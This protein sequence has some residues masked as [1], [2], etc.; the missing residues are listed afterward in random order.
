MAITR[1]TP[2]TSRFNS[3]GDAF[4]PADDTLSAD[5]LIVDPG[6][7][8]ISTALF[9]DGAFLAPTD[10]W[11]VKVNGS[12]VSQT[13]VG[14]F[15]GDGNAA[16]S[17][18]MIGVDGEVQG[19]VGIRLASSGNVNNAG[20]IIADRSAGN[21]IDI[22]NGGTHTITNSGEITAAFAINVVTGTSNDTVRN[23]GIINGDI[24]LSGGN[25]TVT[26]SH[27]IVGAVRLGDGTNRLANSGGIFGE[28]FAGAG[29]DTVTNAGHMGGDV[30]L[31]DGT[32]R[33]TNSGNIFADVFTGTGADTVTNF[34]IIGDVTKSGM[35]S[36]IIFLGAGNDKFTGGANPEM[37]RDDDGADIVSFG[38]GNDTYI[39]IGNTGAD[40]IDIVRGG[41]GIDTYSAS[42]ATTDCA[43][44][45]DTITHDAGPVHPDAGVIAANTALGT[46][47]AATAKD[48]IF[49]FEN[50]DGSFGDD[51]I[52][53]TA[54]DNVLNGWN[55]N[56]FLAGFSG[57]DTLNGGFGNDE[58][59]GGAGKD[60]LTGS[61]G[62]DIFHYT[63]LSESGITAATRDLIADFE[64]GT[65][66]IDLHLID[67]NKTTAA[68]DV[69]TF[70]GNNVPFTGTAGQLHAF[71]SAIGQIIEGDVNGDAKADFSIEIKDATHAITLTGASFTL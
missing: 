44:N 57:N 2:A 13:D 7:F 52:Y 54:T 53:G 63:A 46:H 5:T 69:F 33:L 15:L 19:V 39:A 65:D 8:L 34:A 47:V 6:A 56:D 1:I 12:I 31:G 24:V 27:D 9:F 42:S 51:V 37:V 4:G 22:F 25:D 11:T 41:A 21:G 61:V 10:A 50:A 3:T 67:A 35:I 55:N 16:V 58:L 43:I 18:I 14:I 49:G 26:N 62:A 30:N 28:V 38:G 17:T 64:Q 36:G 29:A 71:W 48:T 66:K 20:T 70:I 23:S 45:L 60:H 40:G 59:V 68:D 32:N